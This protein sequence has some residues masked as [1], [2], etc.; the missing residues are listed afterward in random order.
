MSE[1]KIVANMDS[2]NVI[3]NPDRSP[4][5][6]PLIPLLGFSR[7]RNFLLTYLLINDSRPNRIAGTVRKVRQRR[8]RVVWFF[9]LPGL[10]MSMSMKYLYSANNRRL[11]NS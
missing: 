6:A 5:S 8:N 7:V 4:F 9:F 2:C 1:E 3:V 11:E 10:S